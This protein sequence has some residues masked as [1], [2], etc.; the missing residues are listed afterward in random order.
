MKEA[1]VAVAEQIDVRHLERWVPI[2][3]G[4]AIAAYAL[5]RALGP[6]R[7]HGN[8]KGTGMIANRG[9][10]TRQQLG[11]RHGT[12]VEQSIVINRPAAEL[13][14]FWRDFENLPKFMKH[15]E[16]VAIRDGG[17][18]HW[19][20]KGPGGMHVE[21][22]ARI[23]ND[24]DDR[25]IAWQSLSGSRIA[26]AGSVNFDETDRGTEVRVHFQ[27]RPPAGK[28]GSAVAWLFGEEPGIQVRDDLRRFK[29]L[30][31]TGEIATT[32]GQPSGRHA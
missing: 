26:T 5:Y 22:D 30:M 3:A 18:S 23:I 20:A 9:S 14:R 15:L 17:V 10:D 27:Y 19:V 7:H 6:R 2:A 24:V 31:E 25:I 4:S 12:H 21:W 16:S 1:H 32:E 29:Q 28:L 11:G 8:G 13:Y